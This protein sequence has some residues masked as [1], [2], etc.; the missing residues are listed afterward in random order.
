MRTYMCKKTR[1]PHAV[2][3]YLSD[4]KFKRFIYSYIFFS[5]NLTSLNY[6]L[7]KELKLERYRLSSEGSPNYETVYSFE[8]KTYVK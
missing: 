6:K 7:Y 4:V 3:D 8:G 5:D 2:I 1:R